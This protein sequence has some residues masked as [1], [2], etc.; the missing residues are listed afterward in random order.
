VI[1]V[2][3]PQL[4][5]GSRCRSHVPSVVVC[6][7]FPRILIKPQ[8]GGVRTSILEPLK[9]LLFPVPNLLRLCYLIEHIT[10]L[11]P[12]SQT[13]NV[14]SLKEG[15]G[16]VFAVL[17]PPEDQ[18]PNSI[19]LCLTPVILP[20]PNAAMTGLQGTYDTWGIYIRC[21]NEQACIFLFDI[22]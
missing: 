5:S 17:M 3:C 20:K 10:I 12:R 13:E 4:L 7:Q 8:L 19:K 1:G 16:E 9:R 21:P 6:L 18:E 22:S 11:R 2:L 14:I 15:A